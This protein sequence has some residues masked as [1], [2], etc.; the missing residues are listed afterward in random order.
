MAMAAGSS[1]L[2]VVCVLR[3]CLTD[4][5]FVS[6]KL[7]PNVDFYSGLVYRAMG[8]PPQFFTV[9]F[10]IPRWVSPATPALPIPFLCVCATAGLLWHALFVMQVY[11]SS[12]SQP[13]LSETCAVISSCICLCCLRAV[14]VDPWNC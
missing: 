1:C 5:Y 2:L 10:A 14:G 7:Y 9:L 4:E 11:Q 6:R 13:V 3:R 12:A 8:F